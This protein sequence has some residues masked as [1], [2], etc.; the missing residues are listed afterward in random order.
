[1][2]QATAIFFAFILAFSAGWLVKGWHQ[3]SLELVALKTANEINNASLKA[4]QD[5]ASQS[6]RT[7]ENKLEELANVQPPEIRTEIIKPVF[8]NLCV[9]D[10]FVRMYNEAIDSAER[11]LSGKSTDKMPD[12]ITKVKR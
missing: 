5:L 2:K 7:L 1:M 4:Q 6:A 11:T 12:N 9:S 10:D 3:D 8:T